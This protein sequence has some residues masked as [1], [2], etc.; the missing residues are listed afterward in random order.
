MIKQWADRFFKWFCHPDYYPDIMGDLEETYQDRLELEDHLAQW[1]HLIG[2]LQL[3]RPSL[4][5]PLIKLKIENGM[6]TNYFKISIRSLAKQRLYSIINVVGLAIGLAAFLLIN[7]YIQFEKSY[8]RFFTDSNQIYRLTTDDVK[9]GVIGTRDAMSYHPSG[10]VL[11]EELPEVENYTTTYKFSEVIFRHKSITRSEKMI[12]AADSNYFKIFDYLLI[13]GDPETALNE[14]NSIV[15][16]ES[17]ALAYFGDIDPV[18]K[19]I[20]VLSGYNRPFKVTGVMEDVPENTHYKFNMLVSLKSIQERLDRD[21]WGGFN[22]YTFLKLTRNSDLDE[23]NKKLSPLAKKY[24]GENSNQEFNLQ[25]LESIHLYSDFTFE[26]E[27]HGNH[28]AVSFLVIISIFVLI[29]AWV[30][31]VNLSTARAI[32]RAKEVGLRKVIG[33][34]RNQLIYQFLIESLII[35][36]IG[37]VLAVLIA[38][39]ALPYFNGLLDKQ[40]AV[41]VWNQKTFLITTLIFFV[42]GTFVSGLYPAL[43]LSSFQPVTVLKGKFR[44]SKQGALLRKFLVTVQFAVSIVLIAGTLIVGQQVKYMKSED[45]GFDINHVV[46]F[47]TPRVNSDQREAREQKMKLFHEDLKSHHTIVQVGGTSSMPGGGSSDIASSS[48]GVKIVGMTERLDG[49]VYLQWNDDSFTKTMGMGF[50]AGR[51]FKRELASDSIAIIVNETFLDRLGIND[52]STVL[53]EFVQFGR[54]PENDK[55]KIVGVL[56]NFNRTSLKNSVEPTC[57]FY[58]TGSRNT[59]VKLDE[60]AFMDGLA[61]IEESWKKFFGDAPLDIQFL[62]R[63]FEQLYKEDR[64]FGNVFG[65]FSLLAILVAILGLFGLSSFIAVQRT[66]EVGVRKV[67]GASIGNIISLFYKDFMLLIGSSSLIGFPVVYFVMNKWLS[68]YAYRI[69]FPWWLLLLAFFIISVFAL[70]TVGYQTS[71]VASLDPAK[72]LKY[73]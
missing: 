32:D 57:Y 15:L 22:Y 37:S 3:F 48:G 20:E 12:I 36:F 43:V 68:N 54:S 19:Q 9:D 47:T 11:T 56:Q 62:D 18:G 66:K 13:K 39:L 70:I 63:R 25:P 28:K 17:K 64:R 30:N 5:R 50:V 44:N 58:N 53:G 38:E 46:G 8:D 1:K 21:D 65:S 69:D 72:T 67:L 23:L 55:F 35:N 27:I 16:T 34:Y 45:L 4:M 14:P 29:I 24:I 42:A 41:H 26:P 33:A 51:D 59:V 52:Y 60:N 6:L 49:T 73:E 7:E 71:K 10:K 40:I 2:I 31:Y 61:Y